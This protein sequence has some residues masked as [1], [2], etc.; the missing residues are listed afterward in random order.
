MPSTDILTEIRQA[1]EEA[2]AN[3]LYVRGL[4]KMKKEELKKISR[5]IKKADDIDDTDELDEEREKLATE[6]K[7]L[8][9]QIIDLEND[10]LGHKEELED[11]DEEESELPSQSPQSTKQSGYSTSENPDTEKSEAEEES[12]EE[13]A[14]ESEEDSEAEDSEEE[15]VDTEEFLKKLS[16]IVD[17]EQMKKFEKKRH[18][19]MSKN[20]VEDKIKD[21]LSEF[22]NTLTA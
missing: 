16:Q 19:Y 4:T 14:E 1:R 22:S 3:I 10:E 12:D 11:L 6:K 2:E 18:V 8:E 9:Q 13:S 20:E 21:L 5:L 15:F 17:K 7:T